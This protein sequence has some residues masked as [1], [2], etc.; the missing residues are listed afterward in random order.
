MIKGADMNVVQ[1]IISSKPKHVQVADIVREQI[2]SGAFSKG[3]R[4]LPDKDLALKYQIHRNTVAAGLT[5]LVEEGLLERAPR[6]GTI[7]IKDADVGRFV[8]NAVGMV[9]L[10][11]GDVYGDLCLKF[12]QALALRRLYPVLI[13]ESIVDHQDCVTSYLDH[14][15]SGAQRPFGL[16]IDGGRTFPFDYLK[17]N[18]ERFENIVFIIKYHC[19]EKIKSAR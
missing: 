2:L 16:V 17:S 6:R 13:N 4:L 5:A 18:L 10:G 14:M 3:T 11:K 12:S 8:T 1:G 19:P 15:T 7:V 9:M